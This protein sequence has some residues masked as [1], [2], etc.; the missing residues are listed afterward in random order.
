M[1]AELALQ[2]VSNVTQISNL[3]VKHMQEEFEP[4]LKDDEEIVHLG[5]NFIDRMVTLC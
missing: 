3:A 5:L 2:I 4:E 1:A